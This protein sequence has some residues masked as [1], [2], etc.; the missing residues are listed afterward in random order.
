VSPGQYIREN[1]PI[2]TVVKTSP[3]RLRVEIPESAAGAVKVGTSLTFV[4]DAAPG[5][6]F[7]ATVRELNPSLDPKSRT[8]T[9]EARL[10]SADARLRPGMFVQVQLVMSKGAEAVVVPKR[11]LYNVAG[12]TKV[13]TVKDGRAIEHKIIPG[14]ELAEWVEVPR[15]QINPGDRVVVSALN[16]L[17]QGT[18]VKPRS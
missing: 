2:L 13:F 15:D 9:A 6:Q 17:V 11:A 12:L 4:T 3:L 5:A 16:Q 10:K 8:L 1:T 14:Q 7:A 18:P